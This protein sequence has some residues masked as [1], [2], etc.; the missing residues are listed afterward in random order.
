MENPIEQHK[1]PTVAFHFPTGL[2]WVIKKGKLDKP[3]DLMKIYKSSADGLD[4]IIQ[5]LTAEGV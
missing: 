1:K 5:Y 3:T 2:A 4:K